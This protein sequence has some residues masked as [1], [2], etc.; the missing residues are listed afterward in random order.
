[1]KHYVSAEVFKT[2]GQNDLLSQT[3]LKEFHKVSMGAPEDCATL[4]A[5]NTWSQRIG[6]L[7][8]LHFLITEVREC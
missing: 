6:G 3:N 4:K 7:R 2:A 8:S 5:Q 1:M